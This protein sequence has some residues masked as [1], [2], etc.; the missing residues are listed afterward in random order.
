M[1]TLFSHSVAKPFIACIGKENDG[2]TDKWRRLEYTEFCVG[3]EQT[4]E[5]PELP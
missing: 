5:E 4:Y 1:L 3:I 2:F